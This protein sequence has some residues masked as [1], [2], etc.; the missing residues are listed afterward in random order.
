MKSDRQR[1]HLIQESAATLWLLQPPIGAEVKEVAAADFCDEAKFG[2]RATQVFGYPWCEE[3][4]SRPSVSGE[5]F[6][7]TGG[8]GSTVSEVGI[9]SNSLTTVLE[10]TKSEPW[11]LVCFEL[12]WCCHPSLPLTRQLRVIFGPS[13]QQQ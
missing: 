13:Q 11:L 4:K 3:P 9:S 5:R 7:E 8:P 6:E 2:E 10:L 12:T 1:K